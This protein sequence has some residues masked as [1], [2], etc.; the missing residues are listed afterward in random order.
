M[1]KN[2]I[3]KL[4]VSLLVST[5]VLAPA[6]VQGQ[7]YLEYTAEKPAVAE[8]QPNNTPNR[9]VVSFNGDTQSQIAFNWYTTDLV[10]DAQVWVSTNEDMSDAT[11]YAAEVQEVENEYAERTEDGYFI[12]ADVELDEEEDP[13]RDENGELVVNQGY[14]TDEG[15]ES[16]IDWIEN[17]DDYGIN[18][19]MPVVEHSY[20]AIADNL[21]P[22]TDYY[23]Q[24][25]SENGELSE[26]GTFSTAGEAGEDFQFIHVTDTQNAFFNENTRNE[27]AFGGDTFR[28]AVEAAPEAEFVVH[29]GDWIDSADLE[30]E[31]VDMFDHAQ[32]SLYQLPWTIVP[33]NHD[34]DM[35][36]GGHTYNEFNE[37]F[38]VPNV[39]EAEDTGN[40]YSFDY[41]G[42]HFVVADS[43]EEEFTEDEAMFSQEQMTWIEEDITQAKENGA[44]WIV[45]MYHKPMFSMSYHSLEDDEVQVVR[46][47]LMQLID[48]L[49]VDLVLNGHDHNLSRTKPLVYADNFATAEVDQ[50]DVI[51]DEA[52][53]EHYVNPEGT[54]FS[55]PNTA[56]TKTYDALYNRPVDFIHNAREGLNWI[57]QEQADYFRSL[58]AVGYQPQ[59]SQAFVESHSNYR[60]ADVQTYSVVDVTEDTLTV[61]TY[62]VYGELLEGEERITELADTFGI[63][64]GDNPESVAAPS[65]ETA[66]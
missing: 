57:T 23:Y 39:S 30:D 31:W 13:V 16:E 45:L 9:V 1:N 64:K 66:E 8:I 43:N 62:N 7:E 41:N 22:N 63:Y 51:Y 54:V 4:F 2:T 53:I 37:H 34:Y 61:R 14:F 28:R 15:L 5:Q 49:D 19:F 10:E 20:K 35:V 6:L 32:D 47:E 59:R 56:G 29:T 25:G 65:S 24:V 42:A 52:Y 40:Y 33:G 21:D 38:N 17:G 12:F 48:D 60:D 36:Y 26:V 44:N 46:E 50:A 58:F 55:L 3:G 27:A 11:A 18:E